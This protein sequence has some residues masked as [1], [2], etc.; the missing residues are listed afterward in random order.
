MP[1]VARKA[2]AQ[3]HHRV[4]GEAFGQPARL[5]QARLEVEMPPAQGTAQRASDEDGIPS[6]RPGAQH[7]PTARHG[8]EQRNGE[9]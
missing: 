6:L 1:Q 2:V 9:Q 7:L 8:A 5:G 3:I 4:D